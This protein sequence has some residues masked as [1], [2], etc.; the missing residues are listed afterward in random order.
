[1]TNYKEDIFAEID[2][3]KVDLSELLIIAWQ[4]RI[5]IISFTS[6][7]I[8]ISII[9]ALFLPNIYISSALLTTTEQN[10]SNMSMLG[11][12]SGMASLA[13]ISLPSSNE[14]NKALEAIEII[15]SF[16]FFSEVFLPSILLEDLMAVESWNPDD[17]SLNY[18]D[19]HYD[20][21]T[22][23]WVRKVSYPKLIKPSD[24]EAFDEYTKITTISKNKSFIRLSVQH[25]SP[26][27]AQKWTRLII[28]NINKLMAD[29]DKKRTSQSI[30]FLNN[31]ASKV[32][33]EEVKQAISLLLQEQMK[34]LMLAEASEDYIFKTISSPVAPEIKSEPKRSLIVILAA[35]GGFILSLTLIFVVHYIKGN[36]KEVLEKTNNL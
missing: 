18:K 11:Q 10:K 14:D 9:Y 26:Y 25:Q 35:L 5:F 3:S 4:K 15:K 20:S 8:F 21:N 32:N 12:Y 6:I 29:E 2:D 36:F 19:K 31:Q 16:D 7:F 24:Q 33:Y 17:N 27:I 30:E 13:G 1:M 28:K 34:A 23:K 22:Q